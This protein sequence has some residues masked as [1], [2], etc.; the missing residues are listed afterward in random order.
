MEKYKSFGTLSETT[1][2][3]SLFCEA[4]VVQQNTE[5]QAGPVQDGLILVPTLEIP[6]TCGHTIV[7]TFKN[8]AHAGL[9]L[10]ACGYNSGKE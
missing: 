3:L 5:A 2:F 8:T 10:E 7:W 9:T 1:H 6:S 4:D